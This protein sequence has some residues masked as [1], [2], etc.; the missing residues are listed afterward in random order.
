M[1]SFQVALIVTILLVNV[2]SHSYNQ[3]DSSQEQNNFIFQDQ[4]VFESGNN[5]SGNNSGGGGNSSHAGAG[6][7]GT[8]NTGGGGGASNGPGGNAGDGGKGIVIIRY[9]YQG[10]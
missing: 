1:K 3:L 10:S 6:Q 9:Q 4:T 8:A 5:S 2:L 7:S